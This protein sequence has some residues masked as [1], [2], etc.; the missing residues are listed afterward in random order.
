MRIEFIPSLHASRQDALNDFSRKIKLVVKQ[1]S[2]R[3]YNHEQMVT[4]LLELAKNTIDHSK[5]I[6]ILAYSV[7]SE[8]RPLVLSYIDT[9]DAFDWVLN[10]QPGV[11]SKVGNGVNYGMGLT[12][13]VE[14]A[15]GAGFDLVVER[16]G[17]ATRFKFTR[18]VVSHD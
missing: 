13:I 11:S 17:E 6:G 14:G 16:V 7:P 18:K 3:T 2:P 1:D 15:A 9:G 5:G 10:G 12:L 4:I 8:G